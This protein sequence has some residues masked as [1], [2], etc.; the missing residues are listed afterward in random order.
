MGYLGSKTGTG[1]YQ[2]IVAQ[3]P[4]HDT[5][6]ETHAGT[7]TILHVKPRSTCEIIIDADPEAPCFRCACGRCKFVWQMRQRC[8]DYLKSFD[9][10]SS[11]RVLIY[12]DPPYLHELRG[13]DRYRVEYTRDDHVR[14]LALLAELPA[15]VMISGYPSPVYDELLPNWRT[16]EF[17]T[18]TRGGVRTEKL[19]MNFPADKVHWATFAGKNRTRRQNIKRLAARWKAKFRRHDA[20]TRLAILAALMET[21]NGA[22][23]KINCQSNQKTR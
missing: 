14:L 17:Q 19:W 20:G 3:M 13:R 18:M 21:E 9:W 7:A 4:P 12:A 22:D 6:I 2:A 1:V 23:K 11:G 16:V 10:S 5:Y 15:A 8:E